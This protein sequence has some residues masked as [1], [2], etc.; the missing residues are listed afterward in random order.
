MGRAAVDALIGPAER[1]EPALHAADEAV[2]D[3]VAG[4]AGVSAH[5]AM[6]ADPRERDIQA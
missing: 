3:P 5:G 4:V 6:L 2:G 1:A